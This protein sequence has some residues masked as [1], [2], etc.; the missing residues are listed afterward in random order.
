ME[1]MYENSLDVINK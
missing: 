1:R